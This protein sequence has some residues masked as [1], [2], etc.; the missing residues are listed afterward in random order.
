VQYLLDT[1]VAL[2]AFE[3]KTKLSHK[4]IEALDDIYA[5]VFVSVAS[6]WEVAIKVSNGKLDVTGGVRAFVETVR[7]ND[8]RPIDIN[9]N[10]VEW[11]EAL[12]CIHRDMSCMI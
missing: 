12:P 7:A 3:N 5:E 9:A 1:H 11:V 2:W 8:F 10:H 6:V 4:A